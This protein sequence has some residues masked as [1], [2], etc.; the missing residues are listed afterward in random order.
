MQYSEINSLPERIENNE[1]T[2]RQARNL[3]VEEFY[4]NPL[5]Y[6][7]FP[8]NH[9]GKAA[10]AE[11]LLTAIPRII[12]NWQKKYRTRMPFTMYFYYNIRAITNRRR[13]Q[14][15]INRCAR[16]ALCTIAAADIEAAAAR[17]HMNEYAESFMHTE[18]PAYT[19]QTVSK[20]ADFSWKTKTIP[21]KIIIILTLK[22]SFYLT[23]RTIQKISSRCGCSFTILLNC[24]HTLRLSLERKILSQC[25]KK[26]RHARVFY[27]KI[28][29]EL[30]LLNINKQSVQ[31]DRLIK[32][33]STQTQR[34]Q[35]YNTGRYKKVRI[36]PSNKQIADMIGITTRQLYYY[37]QQSEQLIKTYGTIPETLPAHRRRRRRRKTE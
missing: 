2:I 1:L 21:Q 20:T 30:Q 34:W 15:A 24:V 36:C 17:Y 9:D 10:I 11:E 35:F 37:L 16:E 31:Y 33:L 28:R 19:V 12:D 26:E 27:L 18:E 7:I 8:T 13:K 3:L 5:R 29:Y 25:K 14:K 22:S 32:K 6:G 23:D 4:Q